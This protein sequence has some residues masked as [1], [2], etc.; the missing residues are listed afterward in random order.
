MLDI[1]ELSPIDEKD[2]EDIERGIVR[3]FLCAC[4]H[5]CL[6]LSCEEHKDEVM[7]F[8]NNGK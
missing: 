4:A 7:E 8:L 6:I 1:F 5:A 3:E 2:Y